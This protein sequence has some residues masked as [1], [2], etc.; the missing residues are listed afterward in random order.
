[1]TAEGQKREQQ[2]PPELLAVM[3]ILETCGHGWKEKHHRPKLGD[4]AD[5]TKGKILQSHA[6]FGTVG[7]ENAQDCGDA[8]LERSRAHHSYSE[9]NGGRENRCENDSAPDKHLGQGKVLSY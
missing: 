3:K 8:G 6:V 2:R 9:K 1:M 4:Y 5:G 7:D